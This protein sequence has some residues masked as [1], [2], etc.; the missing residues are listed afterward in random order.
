MPVVVQPHNTLWLEAE[1]G[2]KERTN[3]RHKTTECRDATSDA[4]R[5]KSGD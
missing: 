3:E 2:T 5:N 4:V 1:E